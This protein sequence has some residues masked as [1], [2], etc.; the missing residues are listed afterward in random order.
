MAG[1]TVAGCLFITRIEVAAVAG[2]ILVLAQKRKLRYV[3]VEFEFPP[4]LGIMTFVALLTEIPLVRVLITVAVEAARWRLRELLI[5]FVA[6][7][8]G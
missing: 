3:V 1:V 8:A 2:N 5:G 4:G 7:C 6:C